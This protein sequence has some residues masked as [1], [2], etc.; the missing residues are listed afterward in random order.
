M[1]A[2]EIRKMINDEI[3]HA[4]IPLI[5]QK[6][7]EEN[8]KY[9]LGTVLLWF[10]QKALPNKIITIYEAF[11]L[12]EISDRLQ[13]SEK[14]QS[15]FS[16]DIIQSMNLAF[17]AKLFNE[18]PLY[19]SFYE[20]TISRRNIYFAE[21]KKENGGKLPKG[22]HYILDDWNGFLSGDIEHMEKL[23]YVRAYTHRNSRKDDPYHYSVFPYDDF[24]YEDELLKVL[25]GEVKYYEIDKFISPNIC[26]MM[27]AVELRA[28]DLE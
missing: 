9:G 20:D 8:S 21:L 7:I 13:H 1:H 2:I 16:Y 3:C 6:I 10:I 23:S 19:K 25:K 4:D 5:N 11:Q 15:Y 18:I 14:I 22:S 12:M 26:D 17:L 24:A 27:T 28:I